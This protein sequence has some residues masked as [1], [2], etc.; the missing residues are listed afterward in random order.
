ME[1]RLKPRLS[2]VVWS[3]LSVVACW[4]SRNVLRSGPDLKETH[5]N[6]KVSLAQSASSA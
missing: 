4:R 1:L 5:R 6:A 2:P 3:A